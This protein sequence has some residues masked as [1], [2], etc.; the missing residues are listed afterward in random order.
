MEQARIFAKE[1]NRKIQAIE[2]TK[3]QYL[4]ND[5]AKSVRADLEELKTYCN[6]KGLNFT[7]FINFNRRR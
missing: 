4:K 2:K 1:I 3:S 7:D 6:Y 5:Y